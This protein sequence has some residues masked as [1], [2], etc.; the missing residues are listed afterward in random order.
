VV[1]ESPEAFLV[2]FESA[3]KKA[4]I[5]NK[6]P[7]FAFFELG[8]NQWEASDFFSG[9]KFL[10]PDIFTVDEWFANKD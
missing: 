3:A 6:W 2:D 10:A 7:N 1:Y 4:L 5:E 9:K 8:G